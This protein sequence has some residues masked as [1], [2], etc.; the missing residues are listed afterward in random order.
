MC[1]NFIFNGQLLNFPTEDSGTYCTRLGIFTLRYKYVTYKETTALFIYLQYIL[2]CEKSFVHSVL[3]K[4]KNVFILFQQSV[5]QALGYWYTF[6][7]WP[8]H[9]CGASEVLSFIWTKIIQL[10]LICECFQPTSPYG[11]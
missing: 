10:Q 6:M 11:I 2:G 3:Q 5:F 1:F 4:E 9:K 8:L 7:V